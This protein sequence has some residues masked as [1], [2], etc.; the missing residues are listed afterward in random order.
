MLS[1]KA[2]RHTSFL[3]KNTHHNVGASSVTSFTNSN[4]N[5]FCFNPCKQKSFDN[6]NLVKLGLTTK[7]WNSQNKRTGIYFL[8]MNN[9]DRYAEDPILKH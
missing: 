5:I 2:A 1:I 4:C 8:K 7:G 3:K 6:R 9:I